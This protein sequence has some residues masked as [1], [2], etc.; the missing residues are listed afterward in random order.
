[1]L[2]VHPA[3]AEKDFLPQGSTPI[4]K[5]MIAERTLPAPISAFRPVAAVGIFFGFAVL[6]ILDPLQEFAPEQFLQENRN[7]CYDL[8]RNER[9]GPDRDDFEG[10]ESQRLALEPDCNF[11]LLLQR[12]A[13]EQIFFAPGGRRNPL[14]RLNP[15]KEIQGNPSL[16]L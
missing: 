13:R 5:A 11:R 10:E 3:R 7:P 16:F 14:K 8:I 1:M 4:V 2:Q 6:D 9:L 15:D 12:L